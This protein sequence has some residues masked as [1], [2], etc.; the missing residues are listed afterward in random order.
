RH[1][2]V[3]VV[4]VGLDGGIDA[5]ILPAHILPDDTGAA[6][7]G[8]TPVVEADRD[9]AIGASC[10]AGLELVGFIA[11]RV[12]VNRDRRRPRGAAV[13]RL[14]ELDIEL[15]AVPVLVREIEVAG[16]TW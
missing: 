15:S 8:R 14:R 2:S 4:V 13:D 3:A 16:M 10:D 1:G 9:A 7:A 6:G 12:V 11:R 5:E